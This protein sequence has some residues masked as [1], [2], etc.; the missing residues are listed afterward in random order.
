MFIYAKREGTAQ[1]SDYILLKAANQ[2]SNLHWQVNC[3]LEH[4]FQPSDE[5]DNSPKNAE[6]L[7]YFVLV[8]FEE[9]CMGDL[10]HSSDGNSYLLVPQSVS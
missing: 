8:H 9:N 7:N 10:S 4:P 5:P 3:L 6:K 1:G 2:N